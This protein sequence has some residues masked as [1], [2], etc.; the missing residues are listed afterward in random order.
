MNSLKNQLGED[1]S[2]VRVNFPRVL[3]IITTDTEEEAIRIIEMKTLGD[4]DVE[5]RW[6]RQDGTNC[7]VIGQIPCPIIKETM[8]R[9]KEVY[10]AAL[11]S[12]G[13]PVR[14]I[15]WVRKK[16]WKNGESGYTTQTTGFLKLE[17]IKEVPSHVY[18]G[19]VCYEVKDYVA[20][21]VQCWNCQKMGHIS[22]HCRSNQPVCVRCGT[23]GHRKGDNRCGRRR[24]CCANCSEG[25][26]ASY[27]GC[28]AFL[29]EKKH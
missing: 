13:T 23:R 3:L 26:L 9:K 10:K 19:R 7:G 24:V 5:G 22:N 14:S 17:S 20:D 6:A 15:E 12:S 25:H 11:R 21:A 27:R 8:E 1:L 2:D 28:I 29:R 4:I 16:I 18:L